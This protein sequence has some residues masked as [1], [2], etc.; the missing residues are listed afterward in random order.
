MRN[1]CK[2]LTCHVGREVQR[3]LS[4]ADQKGLMNASKGR[5][6]SYVAVSGLDHQLWTCIMCP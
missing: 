5:L 4:A 2:S 6:A 1:T 3:R